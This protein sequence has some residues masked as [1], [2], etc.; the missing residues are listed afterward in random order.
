MI[1]RVNRNQITEGI[2]LKNGRVG[3]IHKSVTFLSPELGIANA[4]AHGAYKGKSRL[5]GV[6]EIFSRAKIALYHDPVRGSYKIT[7]V[8][9]VFV[10]ENLRLDLQKYYIG[11]LWTE[12]ILRTYAGGGEFDKVFRLVC[13]SMFLLDSC[14][15]QQNDATLAL[16][17]FRYVDALGYL[18]DFE[19]CAKCG[20]VLKEDDSWFIG[21]EGSI[22]CSRCGDSRAPKL[23]PGARRYLSYASTKPVEE[24]LKVELD[25]ASSLELKRAMLAIV[26]HIIGGAL[27]TLRGACGIL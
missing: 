7:E 15:S 14:L 23:A 27:N 10:Y 13:E 3:E 6:S 4:I 24:V 18:P 2:I 16:F 1:A 21:E 11:S 19:S 20:A 17:L 25:S 22:R 5:G 9:P 8:E 26:Q 12:V